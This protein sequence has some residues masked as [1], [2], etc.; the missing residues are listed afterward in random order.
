[1]AEKWIGIVVSG[2][3]AVVV[4]LEFQDDDTV[5]LLNET[6]WKLQQGEK[7]RAFGVMYKT[8]LDYVNE[9]GVQRVVIKGS[10]AGAKGT[11]GLPHLHSAELR[12]AVIAA[13]ANTSA[14]VEIW[15][16][17]RLSKNVGKRNVDAYVDD[18]NFWE[19]RFDSAKLKKGS[20][21]A[22]LLVLGV[23]KHDK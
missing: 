17:S 3:K 18:D 8:V 19:E 14:Q 1:M 2:D 22:A 11:G 5:I 20:R 4:Q 21:E 13:V 9:S 10:S 6:T 12:G 7:P 23:K 15:T 16:K